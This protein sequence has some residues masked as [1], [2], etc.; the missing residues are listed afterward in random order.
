MTKINKTLK[1]IKLL[2]YD[3]ETSLMAFYGF[4]TGEQYLNHKQL[5]EGFSISPIICLSYAINNGPIKTIMYDVTR[6]SSAELVKEFDEIA[7]GCDII[8]GKNSNRFDNKHINTHRMLAGLPGIPEWLDK[9]DDL[10]TQMRKYFYL[11]SQS[12]DYFSK[13]R[14]IGGK[15]TMSMSEWINIFNYQATMCFKQRLIDKEIDMDFVS[16]GTMEDILNEFT[17]LWFKLCYTKV[18]KLGEASLKKMA[19][20]NR[21]DV[22]DTRFLWYDNVKHFTPKFNAS[23]AEPG[24]CKTCGSADIEESYIRQR[25]KTVYQYFTCLEHNGYAGKLVL[26]DGEYDLTKPMS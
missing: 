2:T 10:E 24:S 25:G 6:G 21:K 14:G 20:Y 16:T 17:Q 5:I 13:L 8:M 26:K 11:P 9:C 1:D 12:L 22:A 18:K 15:V 23:V 7:K 4:A 3:I 19:F